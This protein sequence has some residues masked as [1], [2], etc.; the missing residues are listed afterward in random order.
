MSTTSTTPRALT[1]GRTRRADA[2]DM[3]VASF[4]MGLVGLLV[5]N[6][7]LGP[8][9]LVLGGLALARHTSRPRRALLG[10]ALGAADLIVLA[11]LVTTGGTVSWNLAG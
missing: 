5:F 11:T 8:C 1:K 9:A 6:I 3:A 10:L 7:V 2:D 4:V